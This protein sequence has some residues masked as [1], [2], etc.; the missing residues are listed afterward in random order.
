MVDAAKI[1]LYGVILAGGWGTRFW[2]LSRSQ[3]PK[4]VLRLLG[5]ESMLQTTVERLLPRIP[6]QRQAVVT[7][8]GQAELIHQELHRKGWDEVRIWIEPEGKNT[9]AAV[10]LAAVYLGEAA[11]EA[12]MAVFPADHFIRDQASLL[13]ALDLAAHWAQAGYLVTFGIP[14]TRPETGYGYI[15]QGAPLDDQGKVFRTDRFIEKPPLDRATEFVA[16]GGYYWNSGIFVFRRDVLLA[17]MCRYLPDLYRELARLQVKENRPP[18]AEVY[19][20][21]PS[22]SL[23]HGILEKAENVAVVPVEMGWN[24]V[25]TWEAVHE[26]F[27]RDERANVLLGRVLDQGSQDCILFAQNRLV[28]TIGLERIIVVDTPDATLVCHRDRAQEVK[29][30]VTELHRQQMVESVQHTTVERPWG[31]YTVMDEGPSFKVKRIVVDPGQKLS[32]QVHQHRAE[33]WVVVTGTARVT[34]GQ[35]VSLVGSNQSVYIPQKT[36]HR[37]E[38]P[39]VEPIQLIEVQTG[40]YLEEDDI[41]RLED[42]YWHPDQD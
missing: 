28:A 24:D 36:P 25:G 26:L 6:A 5:S 40:V 3:Y 13:Q 20:N 31:R 35:E 22:I 9:A 4:Q 8:A 16:A 32:L 41:Q 29:D 17:A 12:V 19:Q 33:H 2:P 38:N 10:G 21:C 34:I 30:L 11:E 37:L 15:K 7:N 23:D 1:P 27:P 18:L 14:P 39:T 42:D